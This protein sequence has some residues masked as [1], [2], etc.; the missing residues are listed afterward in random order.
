M[1]IMDKLIIIFITIVSLS[2]FVN[3]QY[4]LA[5]ITTTTTGNNGTTTGSPLPPPIPKSCPNY[6]ACSNCTDDSSC[7]WCE[8]KGECVEGTW[9][10]AKE[11][12]NVC[13]DFR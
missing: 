6:T 4:I 5:N 12:N 9:Y 10:G 11:T 1:N 3:S 2:S 8:D 13:K 7:I